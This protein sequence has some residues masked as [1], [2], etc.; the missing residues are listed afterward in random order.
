M[1]AGVDIASIG[2]QVDTRPVVEGMKA[3][4]ALGDASV[5]VEAR[6]DSASK[7]LD[8]MSAASANVWRRGGDAA[9]GIDALGNSS[10]KTGAQLN[11]SNGQ[12]ADTAK[13]MQMQA[14]QAKATAQA[15]AGLGDS[16]TRLTLGQLALSEKFREQ[17]ATLG[18]SRSQLMAHQAAQMGLTTEV[19]KSIA[20]FKAQED[21]I[22]AAAA[23]KAE[24]E[25]SANRLSEAL[26]LLAA[27][28]AL[29]KVGEYIKDAT[30]LAARY[31][32]L[33]VVMEVVGRNAGY[34]KTQMDFA[35]Q[36]VAKQGITMVESRESVVK[37]VQ[38]HVDLQHASE[39]A[40]IAQ[41]AA[42][43]GHMN[44][45]EAF[46]RLVNGIARGN[47][48]ILRNIGIN[49][50]LQS[51]Y[52]EM[53]DS[54]GK[55]TKELT[56]NERVEA[57]R[58]AVFER[59]A[60]ING[61]YEKSMDTAGKQILSMQRYTQ[62]FKTTFGETF[63]EALTIGVMGLTDHLK[64]SNK[65]ITDL[66][67]NNQLEEWGHGITK[68]FVGIVS[69]VSNAMTT[70]QKMNA[71]A[72]H[73]ERRKDI[74]LSAD[75]DLAANIRDSKLTTVGGVTA[76]YQNG[77]RIDSVRQAALA[78]EN[79]RYEAEQGALNTNYGRF[80]RAADEREKTRTAKRKAEADARLAVDQ[81]YATDAAAIRLAAATKGDAEIAAAEKKVKA[82]HD[83]VYV[84][85]PNY[86]DTEGREPKP[87]VDAA[88]NTRLADQLK[89]Y[90][91]E[92]ARAKTE[93]EYL[94]KLDDMRHK[95][96]EIGDAEYFASR[97]AFAGEI[98]GADIAAYDKQLAELRKHHNNTEGEEAK[99]AKAIH[100]IEDKK[101]AALQKFGFEDLTRDEEER[102]RKA[103]IVSA[104]DDA[105][106]KYI[107]SLNAQMIAIEA[108][109]GKRA[110]SA[111]FIA[112]ETAAQ[113][114]AAAAAMEIQAAGPDGNGHTQADADAAAAMLVTLNLQATAQERIAAALRDG[115]AANASR[116][117]AQQA[118]NDWKYAGESIAESLSS[119]FGTAGKAM[120][121]MFK[122]YAENSARQLQLD[123]QM[124]EAKTKLDSDPTKAL[125][126]SEIQQKGAQAQ[127]K[128]YGDMSSAAKGFFKEN[129]VG[130]R[131]MEGAEKAYRAAEMAMAIDSMLVKSGLLTGY[132][133]LF[134]ASKATETAAT[135][136]SIGPDVAA[137][138]AKGTAAAAAGVASQAAGDPYNAWAR[139][140]A[141]AAAMAALG[142]AVM[143]GG[144]G[145]GGQTAAEVQKVQGTGSV[146]GDSS[147]KSDSIAR[148]IALSAANSN[149]EL[150][151]TAGMLSALK[152]IDASM[153]GLTNLV[154]G[155]NG[156]TDGSNLG[157]QTGTVSQ[158]L[159]G[160]LG[161]VTSLLGK[162]PLVGSLVGGLANLWGKTTQNIV[163]SGLQLGGSVNDLQNGKGFS[164]Y[165]SVD[166]TKS[167][168]FGLSKKTSNSVQT[169]GLGSDLSSQFGMI[170]TNLEDTLK[171]AAGGLGIGADQVGSA[172]DR[173]VISTTK[174][175][176][177]DLKGDEL[178]AAINGVISKTMDEMAAAA[179][180]GLDRFRK[181]GEG[182]AETVVRIATDYANVDGILMGIGKTFGA[183]G[184]GSVPA[185]ENLI[186][187]AGGIDE[188][189]SQTKG[190]AENF[191]SQAEQL[192]PVS[193]YVAEQLSAMGLAGVQTRDDFKNV[194]LGLNLADPAAQKTYASLMALQ[195]AFAKTHAATVDLTKTEQEIADERADLQKQYDQLTLNSTQLR[196]KERAGIE[197]S[198][199]A[200]F[201]S[202]TQLQTAAD[203]SATLK[204][205]VTSL[206][207]FRKSIQSFSNAQLLGSLSP[208]TAMQK[209]AE[210]KRQYEAML[211][212]ANAGDETARAGISAA[213][214]AF[215]AADQ[216]VN[217]S[218]AAYVA[219]F[220]KVQSD[221]AALD[222]IAG[223]QM[224]DAQAQLSALD[225][226]TSLLSSLNATAVKIETAMTAPGQPV[227]MPA[228]VM[229]WSEVGT[230]NMAPLV[231]E[232]KGLRADNAE[233]KAALVAVINNQTATVSKQ[234]DA[235]VSAT[236]TAGEN[237]AAA[238]TAGAAQTAAAASWK[239][240]M[241][242]EA[243]Q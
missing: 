190:F 200:L 132:T 192:A 101:S 12:M 130:Y 90:E 74:G 174:I 33:G 170:F 39:L 73:M 235:V 113:L 209:D 10:A 5:R 141:M 232:V 214:T 19:S 225:Q 55:T 159:T 24:A 242:S 1:G 79:A 183:V 187:L 58:I 220:A 219:N 161:T 109:N 77:K 87:K 202:I 168:W 203:M 116:K 115:E 160:V 23:A 111:S 144:S 3:L 53:A 95:A 94:M 31:E 56:E 50:N 105:A 18:M 88:E 233:L 29:L 201:D 165:A 7:A 16:T 169:Q 151:Y 158:G 114:R 123:Q 13:L 122:G 139:M 199:L 210:A 44:S 92:A 43:I 148:S 8:G 49:V 81:K 135:V 186:V 238:V 240:Q 35:S 178:T 2:I 84:G 176:L 36:S 154:V 208:M 146:F 136:A 177:K 143:G 47:V 164:Q 72:Q 117:L 221:L 40:R 45:S 93:T 234:T 25:K 60:D 26:K 182:Y 124:A 121:E 216:I 129:S 205:S 188:L 106:N 66:S 127:L 118:I 131:A 126:I 217:A 215:L 157:I 42:V 211:A 181:V 100:D 98:V 34:T 64:D 82:L 162:I 21:A 70:F 76:F 167:S 41:N 142:F 193:K 229:N 14:D 28:Y 9:K 134:V 30:M 37:L 89:R 75:A 175:S 198:N 155:A 97:K 212:K 11:A 83:Q 91:T 99:N 78:E 228:P 96:G 54:L 22:K 68:V 48:L 179:V 185:R 195:E 62:D 243:A 147:A 20:V 107:D 236:L 239:Q 196:A 61:V 52:R 86:R 241:M 59:G 204:T 231:E 237:N 145:G 197:A 153:S 103:A 206:D 51:A 108:A 17:A 104:S 119:A 137:S 191:L 173:M 32:T 207:T 223:K 171:V 163:D 120:G 140:A 15:N 227:T 218:S 138:V 85:T 172:L 57:R 166:T 112:A 189:A 71:F 226:Q 180:P 149:I 65:S 184:M 63:N 80:E 152:R 46:D 222:A 27:G 156:V 224:T 6:T 150:N 230:S 38:A 133:G 125:A 4:D 110:Q 194:V 69:A 128:S 102:L 213:A 67:K